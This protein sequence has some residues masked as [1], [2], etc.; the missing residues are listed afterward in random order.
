MAKAVLLPERDIL[1]EA[2][3][4]N[5]ATGRLKWRARPRSHFKTERGHRIHLRRFAGKFADGYIAASGHRQVRFEGHLIGVHRIIWKLV[6]GDDPDNGID[7]IN[8]NPSYNMWGNLRE[9]THHQNMHNKA[10][11]RDSRLRIKGV[12][13]VSYRCGGKYIATIQINKQSKYLGT[14]KTAEEAHAAYMVAAREA[15]GEFAGL[16]ADTNREI[17]KR[18][19]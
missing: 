9:A 12:H 17:F 13:M 18:V 16:G 4:Y 10:S 15:F 1:R 14:F 7:H 3:D 11:R 19:S 2:F 8:G 6:T 5:P